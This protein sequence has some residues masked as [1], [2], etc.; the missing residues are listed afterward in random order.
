MQ[1]FFRPWIFAPILLLLGF[2][3]LHCPAPSPPEES[4]LQDG[5]VGEGMVDTPPP[6]GSPQESGT[7]AVELRQ[8][9]FALVLSSQPSW[10]L[11][12]LKQ[13]EI[14]TKIRLDG[15]QLG[16]VREFDAS[17][18]YDPYWL[19]PENGQQAIPIPGLTWLKPTQVETVSNSEQ[20]ATFTLRY[21]QGLEATLEIRVAQQGTF[22]FQWKPKKTEKLVLMRLQ[23]QVDE[24]E[25][26]YGLGEYFDQVAHRGKLR[27]MQIEIDLKL[28]S[29]YNEA[30]FPVPFF[31]GTRGWG[32]F[33]ASYWPGVFDMGRKDAK[34]IEIT[35]YTQDMDFYLFAANHPLEVP[36]LYT[37]ISGA[38]AV[39]APW[40]FGTMLWRDENK[41]QAEVLDDAAQIRKHD[42][43][44][45]TM[46]IDRPYDI[47]VN[48]FGWD[49]QRFPDHKA[50]IA[51]LHKQGFRLGLWSTPYAEK[52]TEHHKT[53]TDK[54]WFVQLGLP[55]FNN[56]SNPVDLTNPE[57]FAFW[58]NLIRRYTDDGIE[59]FKLDYGED[60][61]VGAGGVGRFVT[62]FHNGE[63]ERTMHH[64]YTLYYHR[65]YFE[66]LPKDGGFLICRGGT[67]GSQQYVSIVWPGDLDTGFQTHY[68][69][70]DNE[71]LNGRCWVGGLVASLIGGLTLSQSG[72]PFYG[73]DT[74]GYRNGRPVKRVFI[75]WGQQTALSTIMQIGGAD[76]NVNPWDFTAYKDSQFD[77]QVLK[78]FRDYIR[79]H[80]RLFPYLYTYA[81]AAHR[82]EVGP[83]RPYG[84]AFPKE[85]HHPND[86]YLLGD[87]L[88]V[89]PVVTDKDERNVRMPQGHDWID[90][91]NQDRYKGGQSV[92]YKADL[93]TLPL[94]LRTGSILPLL[95][96]DID[97]LAPSQETG[98]VSYA[99]DPGM[100]SLLV[101]P[102]E[103]ASLDLFDGTQLR[104]TQDNDTH[105]S[106]SITPGKTFTKGYLVSVWRLQQVQKV[107]A[108]QKDLTSVTSQNA[109]ESCADGCYFWDET[110]KKLWIHLPPSSQH[111]LSI[112]APLR[113]DSR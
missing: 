101:V 99:N 40:A 78:N 91:W 67:W 68:Q 20:K 105:L 69:C 2:V 90:W 89:A 62:K 84:I 25:N 65:A 60:I 63:D 77:E 83:T 70:T 54:G 1:R 107:L 85:N 66:N 110:N 94:F 12:L 50:M 52:K 5:S 11:H 88:M 86:Q 92:T 14:L 113:A 55:A 93:D 111:L 108:Q 3:C 79:L 75:R 15:F 76:P 24:Q 100:L 71:K 103:N 46:W 26:Y 21:E 58:K 56:W 97:T 102:G 9:E 18:N 48:N 41:D 106:L 16:H 39:P 19:A 42:L 53:I 45:S 6:D 37:R 61:Q 34:Q 109:V 64:K 57:A 36:G 31:T 29:G 38:P 27:A 44:I 59:G 98:V 8:G 30:H 104:L 87:F 82:H 81:Q 33:V 49:P 22:A 23:C 74:G 32:L 96:P 51:Q 28:E 10:E 73:S 35:Y 47:A 72:F 13:G 7:K 4:S 80:T 112:T 17:Y 95:R 43:A